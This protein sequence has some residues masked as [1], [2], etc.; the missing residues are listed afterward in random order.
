MRL[1]FRGSQPRL[2]R[3]FW[4]CFVLLSEVVVLV[5]VNR[6]NSIDYKINSLQ[7]RLRYQDQHAHMASN[8]DHSCNGTRGTTAD[9]DVEA[10]LRQ[11]EAIRAEILQ[12]GG[13][14]T[15]HHLAQLAS[16]RAARPGR[17][18]TKLISSMDVPGEARLVSM[19]SG[20]REAA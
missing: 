18:Q 1:F 10:S 12:N 15:D 13:R 8:S 20:P 19:Q 4:L 14:A 17:L 7:S 16:L 9:D 2:A 11:R 3:R 5:H 6:S